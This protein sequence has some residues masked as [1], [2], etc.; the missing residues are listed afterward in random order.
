MDE[1]KSEIKKINSVIMSTTLSNLL[2]E[3]IGENF[4]K[5]N[6]HRPTTRS[7]ISV[8]ENKLSNR[9]S[10]ISSTKDTRFNTFTTQSS[11]ITTTHKQ[12]ETRDKYYNYTLKR[13]D[14]IFQYLPI[15]ILKNVHRT[16]KSQPVSFEG[17][18]NF[19]KMFEKTLMSEIGKIFSLV[20]PYRVLS[21]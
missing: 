21:I 20:I 1:K 11:P 2:P 15:D 3:Q 4:T 17:K 9:Y 18:L 12:E 6:K 13:D 10:T 19:L 16:L 8:T 7:D 14:G 5:I